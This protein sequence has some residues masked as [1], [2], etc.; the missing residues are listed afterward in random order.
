MRNASIITNSSSRS[1]SSSSSSRSSRRNRRRRKRSSSSSSSCCCCCCQF[2]VQ[3]PPCYEQNLT[4][5]HLSFCNPIFET[6]GE[7]IKVQVNG[8]LPKRG[9]GGEQ[10]T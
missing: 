10:S 5:V 7:N 4:S 6:L 9:G 1:S 2:N 8:P 3:L